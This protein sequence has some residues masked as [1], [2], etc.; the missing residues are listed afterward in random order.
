MNWEN[1]DWFVAGIATGL[2]ITII[3]CVILGRSA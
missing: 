3:I 2:A 1:F